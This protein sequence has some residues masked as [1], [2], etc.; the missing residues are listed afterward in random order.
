MRLRELDS[1]PT[2]KLKKDFKVKIEKNI[3]FRLGRMSSCFWILRKGYFILLLWLGKR[4]KRRSKRFLMKSFQ[5]RKKNGTN[6][7]LGIWGAT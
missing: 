1:G 6:A 4:K 2:K 3:R 7:W 5:F